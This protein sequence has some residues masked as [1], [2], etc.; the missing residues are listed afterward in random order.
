MYVGNRMF[1]YLPAPEAHWSKSHNSDK[2][3]IAE[4]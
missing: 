1:V 2:I 3:K 4:F